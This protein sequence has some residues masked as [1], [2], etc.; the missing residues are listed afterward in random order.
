MTHPVDTVRAWH[1]AVNAGDLERLD[2]LVTDDVEI[3]GP[4]GISAGR[5]M[6]H[7]WIGRAKINLIPLR[8]WTRGDAAVAEESARWMLE[9]GEMTPAMTAFSAFQLADD[10]I[11]SITRFETLSEALAEAGLTAADAA[12]GNESTEF[13]HPHS[14]LARRDGV[15][16]A[17]D[18]W[19]PGAGDAG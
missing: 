13:H 3:G 19:P 6:H 16:G 17:P 4:R 7:E 5:K 11:T 8:Y 1:E 18:H 14:S 10:R 12:G 9:N 15:P 2:G